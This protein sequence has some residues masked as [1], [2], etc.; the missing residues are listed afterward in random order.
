MANYGILGSLPKAS[1]AFV[2]GEQIPQQRFNN[3]LGQMQGILGIEGILQQR[4]MQQQ[5]AQA[6]QSL[7]PQLTDPAAMMLAQAGDVRGA[8][9]RQFPQQRERNPLSV[10]GGALIPDAGSPNG[11]KFMPTAA[12]KEPAESTLAKLTRERDSIPQGDPRRVHYDNAILKLTTHAPAAKV[13]TTILPPQKT[14]EN[15]DKLRADYTA[16]PVVKS[17]AEMNTAFGMIEAAYK[18]PSAANDLAMATKYMKILDPT[19][20]VRES[21]FALAVNATGLLD[22]VRNYAAQI[23]EGKKLNPNQRKDFYDSAK[24]INDAF[25]KQREDVDR[26]YSEMTTGYG[27]NPKNVI[28]SLRRR[29]TD[30]GGFKVL[31]VE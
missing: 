29:A 4:A 8:I 18:R 20:V 10:A 23:T 1:A 9:G 7:L 12:P 2:A 19:S 26:Q 11:Y 25:Q 6:M 22:K 21:E 15:E 24:A 13:N 16:N 5:Q 14:F 31:G 28:P 27:L 30:N 17:A 3:Q